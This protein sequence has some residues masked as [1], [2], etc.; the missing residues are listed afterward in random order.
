[1]S[2]AMQIGYCFLPVALR[3]YGRAKKLSLGTLESLELTVEPKAAFAAQ[4]EPQIPH[5]PWSLPSRYCIFQADLQA[6]SCYLLVTPERVF[7]L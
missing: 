2:E 4:C 1:M 7:S 6:Q 5:M 3:E